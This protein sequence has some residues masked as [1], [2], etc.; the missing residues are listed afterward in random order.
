M[1]RITIADIAR[2]AGVSTGAVSY[3]LNGRAG[4]SD[5]TR[6]RI[7]Q[8]AADLGWEPSQ[9]A[10]ALSGA[11][12]EAVGLILARSPETLGFE[13]FYMQFIAGIEQVLSQRDFALMLQVVP[14]LEA[15]IR[16]Y[17]RWRAAGRVD[18]VVMVDPRKDDPRL[19]LLAAPDA[20]PAVVVGNPEL[21]P[22]MTT[23]WTDDEAAV[24][25]SV[26]YL[27]TLG[28]R[29]I[30]RV[31]GTSS[32]GHV[33]IRD[34]AFQ[35]EV[36][37]R[38]GRG[39][40]AP[41]DFTAERG[42]AATRSLLTAPEPVTALLFDNDVMALSGSSVAQEL[43]LR[44]PEDVSIIAWDDSP[45]CE[46]AF[47]P[48]TALSHDVT[49]YGAHAARRLFDRMD[50]AAPGSFVDATPVLRVRGSTGPVRSRAES[51]WAPP[52]Q[53]QNGPLLS[54]EGLGLTSET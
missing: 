31:S 42:A 33:R 30:G 46:A 50:G 29:R 44:V 28:H 38:G 17:R 20:L 39:V 25:E 7:L 45:L 43:G 12:S 9:A 27:T 36:A 48:L 40:I 51:G 21:A 34:A 5:S 8:I 49:A 52:S 32:F 19:P 35:D 3:A 16:T 4:V 2:H 26:R 23:V 11:G 54:G 18:G 1:P 22:G 10:R 13:S 14:D 47:P 24:R 15:E 37:A 6:R 41:A 53:R